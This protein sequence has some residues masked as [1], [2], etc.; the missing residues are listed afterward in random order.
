VLIL[1]VVV[2]TVTVCVTMLRRM[3]VVVQKDDPSCY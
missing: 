3:N 1:L 2:L